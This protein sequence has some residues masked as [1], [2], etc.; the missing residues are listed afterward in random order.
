MC[1]EFDPAWEYW[2]PDEEIAELMEESGRL[3]GS[4]DAILKFKESA[5]GSKQIDGVRFGRLRKIFKGVCDVCG[6][7]WESIHS[8]KRCSFECHQVAEENKSKYVKI[9]YS[10]QKKVPYENIAAMYL[11]GLSL[12]KTAKH[13]QINYATVLKAL[14]KLGIKRRPAKGR[15]SE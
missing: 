3:K 4:Y 5:S 7:E 15:K 1:E 13:M 11:S 8:R 12:H 6:E 2:I 9:G 14:N 10:K